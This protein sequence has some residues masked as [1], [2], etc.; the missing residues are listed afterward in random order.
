DVAHYP[1]PLFITDAAM[2][3]YPTLADKRDI[4]QNAIDLCH[5]LGLAQPK[6]AILSAVETVTA[7]L[8]STVEASALC[9]MADRGQIVGGLLDGPLAFDNAISPEAAADKGIVSAVAGCADILVA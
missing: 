5:A 7:K 4:V 2:N 9:K 8:N 6:V 3:V 1:K